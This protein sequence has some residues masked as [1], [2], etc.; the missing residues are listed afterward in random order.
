M[1]IMNTRTRNLCS[2]SSKFRIVFLGKQSQIFVSFFYFLFSGSS[3]SLNRI[4][5]R[6]FERTFLTFSGL[7]WN[8]LSSV[9]EWLLVDDILL[10]LLCIEK[11][12]EER[13]E[14]VNEV[15]A[16]LEMKR[17]E[18]SSENNVLV[19]SFGIASMVRGDECFF[20]DSAAMQLEQSH[21]KTY[22]RREKSIRSFKAFTKASTVQ[23][24]EKAKRKSHRTKKNSPSLFFESKRH[25]AVNRMD[26]GQTTVTRETQMLP[27]RN[28]SKSSCYDVEVQQRTTKIRENKWFIERE[29]EGARENNVKTGKSQ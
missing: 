10:S 29:R 18:R 8:P 14:R 1:I 17:H 22:E 13:E 16:K 11:P 20:Q 23:S 4:L 7:L 3:S 19:C 25:S 24:Q 28:M 9:G 5:L 27:W 2:F 6:A 26:D 12:R 15:K 21:T